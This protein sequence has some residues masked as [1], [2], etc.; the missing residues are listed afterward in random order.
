MAECIVLLPPM[1]MG[2]CII[3]YKWMDTTSMVTSNI[4][5]WCQVFIAINW[6]DFINSKEM[7]SRVFMA[8]IWFDFM[9]CIH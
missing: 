5:K 8:I 4:W 1:F 2:L 3:T 6:I 9:Q 7:I